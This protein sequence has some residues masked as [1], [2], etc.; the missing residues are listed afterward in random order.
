LVA[1]FLVA[2]V[3]LITTL[4]PFGE[5]AGFEVFGVVAE[6]FNDLW[7]GA[8]VVDPL[9]DFV[10]D[11]LGQAGDFAVAFMIRELYS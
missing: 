10:A 1:P 6:V 8:A 11:G 2:E 5:M 4:A 3:I 7:V 9:V